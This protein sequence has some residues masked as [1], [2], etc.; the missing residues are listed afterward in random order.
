M[1]QTPGI[2]NWMGPIGPVNKASASRLLPVAK[3]TTKFVSR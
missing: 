1:K 3:P 2:V